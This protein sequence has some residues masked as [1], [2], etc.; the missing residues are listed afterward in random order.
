MQ[1]RVLGFVN[2]A[3][4]RHRAFQRCGNARWFGRALDNW[5]TVP[6]GGHVKCP[7]SAKSTDAAI[8]VMDAPV[9]RC[10]TTTC[11]C[12]GWLQ[13]DQLRSRVLPR[14]SFPSYDS[15]AYYPT[16]RQV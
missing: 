5:G 4:P 11:R 8:F 16:Q 6:L 7:L 9:P 1:P 15:T 13:L 10:S 2:D 3:I 12:S 14:S